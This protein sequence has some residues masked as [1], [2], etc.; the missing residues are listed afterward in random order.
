MQIMRS[1]T[2]DWY[3]A[4]EKSNLDVGIAST[5]DF[6]RSNGEFAWVDELTQGITAAQTDE[7]VVRNSQF[8]KKKTEAFCREV[9]ALNQNLNNGR[10][11]ESSFQCRTGLCEDGYCKGLGVGGLCHSHEDC[12]EGLF[13]EKA[14]R[15]PW[16][17]S[18]AKLRT[19]YQICLNDNECQAGSYC[20]YASAK[21]VQEDNESSKQCLPYYSKP[22]QLEIAWKNLD[23]GGGTWDNP[24]YE[25]L[26]YNG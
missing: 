1:Y 9:A 13:C 15:W 16:Q 22:S 12:S 8:N 6:S 25:D 17:N 24:T 5:C 20:W 26:L 11:C 10:S 18:C 21:N 3:V 23:N 2:C 19:S 4:K 7:A 14:N